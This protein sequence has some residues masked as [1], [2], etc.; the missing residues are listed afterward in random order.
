MSG[1]Y[2][3]QRMIGNTGW[4]TGEQVLRMAVGLLVGIWLARYLGPEQYG[5]FSYAIAFAM[6]FSQMAALG[7]G[8]IMVRDLV[9]HTSRRGALLGTSFLLMT[10]GGLAVF[11]LAVASI[12]VLRPGDTLMHW[13]VG[14]TMAGAL[15]QGTESIECW[16]ASQLQAKYTVLARSAAFLAASLVKGCL[17]LM[18]APLI[19]FAWVGLA[20]LMIGAAGLVVIYKRTGFSFSTWHFDLATAR[21]QLKDGWPLMLAVGLNM[22]YLRIDQVILGEI[23]GSSELGGYSAAVRISELWAFLPAVICASVFP[24]MVEA[25]TFSDELFYAQLQKL[26]NL[27][28]FIAYLVAIPITFFSDHLVQLLYGDAYTESGRL[29]AVLVWSGLFTSLGAVQA[30]FLI[31]KHWSRIYL[32]CMLLGCLLNVGLNWL[33]IP[34]MGAM[35]AVIASC[36][37]YWFAVHGT[38]FIFKPLRKNAWMIAKAMLY[39]KPW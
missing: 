9:R 30:L 20:E 4:M 2:D 13:L 21:D 34:H 26:Y 27:M 6:M 5:Q 16:Y 35:G 15:F 3:L 37:S 23:A 28:V 18:H 29:L 8:E 11:A 14:I 12:F 31:S 24:A 32:L 38:C 17:I 19:A 22:V 25:G 33:L 10:C 39:P 36:V 7:L 1:R